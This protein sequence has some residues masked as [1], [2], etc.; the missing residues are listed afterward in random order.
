MRIS[1]SVARHK[2]HKRLFREA[3]G[4]YGGRRNLLRTVKESIVRNRCFAYRDRRNRKRD[5]RRLWIVRITAACEMRGLKYSK[6]I[7]GLDRAN[8]QL[9]RK[10]LSELAIHN[11]AIFDEIAAIVREHLAKAAV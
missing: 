3:K 11:P 2:A 8:I 9:N 4:Q 6:F 10:A 1:Y 5:F 7:H